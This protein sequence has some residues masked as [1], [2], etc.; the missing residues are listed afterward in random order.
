MAPRV[1]ISAVGGGKKLIHSSCFTLWERV[2]GGRKMGGSQCWS[3]RFAEKETVVPLLGV[4]PPVPPF[5]S[6]P[7]LTEVS[8]L[9]PPD[10]TSK[11]SV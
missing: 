3:R 6:L 7:T 1:L 2:S 10:V 11:Y 4:S 8:R 9:L 5:C